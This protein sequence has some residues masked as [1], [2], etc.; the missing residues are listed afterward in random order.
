MSFILRVRMGKSK[1]QMVLWLLACIDGLED[2]RNE[3]KKKKEMKK[4]KK[5]K[6]QLVTIVILT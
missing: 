1:L 6:V 2:R 3:E 4:K 5:M